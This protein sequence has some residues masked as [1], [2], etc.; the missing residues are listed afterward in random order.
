[1]VSTRKLHIDAD[2]GD[3]QRTPEDGVSS[4][5]VTPKGARGT[6]FLAWTREFKKFQTLLRMQTCATWNATRLTNERGG[7]GAASPSS[8]SSDHSSCVDSGVG[9]ST[10]CGPLPRRGP[11]SKDNAGDVLTESIVPQ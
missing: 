6:H 2:Q 5:G 1:M 9:S 8:G 7:G 4:L 3:P 11:A 10:S